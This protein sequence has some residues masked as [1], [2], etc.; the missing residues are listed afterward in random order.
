MTCKILGHMLSCECIFRF[1]LF[2]KRANNTLLLSKTDLC[3]GIVAPTLQ[4][5]SSNII[6]IIRLS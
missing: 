1:E 2:M 4:S 6:S 5:I 3:Q